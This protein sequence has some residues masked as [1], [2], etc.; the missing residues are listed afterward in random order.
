[1]AACCQGDPAAPDIV[2]LTQATAVN[3]YYGWYYG[4][5]AGIGP[6]LDGLRAKHPH[7]PLA[8]SNMAPAAH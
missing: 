2:G 1:M 3:R 5:P 4:K 7:Q 8:L 6:Y